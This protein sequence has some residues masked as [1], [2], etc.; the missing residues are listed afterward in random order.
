MAKAQWG[1]IIFQTAR[2]ILI[3]KSYMEDRNNGQ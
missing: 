3:F 2:L 1:D